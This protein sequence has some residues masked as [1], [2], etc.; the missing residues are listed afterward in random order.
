MRFLG[1][2]EN[3]ACLVYSFGIRDDWSVDSAMRDAGCEVHSFD[4]TIGRPRHC[5]W[6]SDT[7]P[8]G[9][10]PKGIHFHPVGLGAVDGEKLQ[11]DEDSAQH[12]GA[13]ELKTLATIRRELGHSEREITVLKFDIEGSEWPVLA[14]IAAGRD[15]AAISQ[16]L[17]SGTRFPFFFL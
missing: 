10:Q 9:C 11:V 7:L 6:G 1:Q 16:I 3:T 14:Q 12:G 2:R 17:T 5:R 15:K 4:P 13:G 8:R